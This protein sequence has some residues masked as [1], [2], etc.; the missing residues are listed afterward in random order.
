[1]TV[2]RSMPQIDTACE[3]TLFLSSSAP[4]WLGAEQIILAIYYDFPTM[5]AVFGPPRA[6]A[7][8]GGCPDPKAPDGFFYKTMIRS[9]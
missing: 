6:M 8:T 3:A 7:Q 4:L 1:M 2:L 5:R 9:V